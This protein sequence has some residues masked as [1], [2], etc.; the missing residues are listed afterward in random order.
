MLEHLGRPHDIGREVS[1]TASIGIAMVDG[2]VDD[3][4][5]LL[6]RADVAMYAAKT[7]GKGRHELYEPAMRDAGLVPP[8]ARGGAPPGHR[9]RAD[10]RGL[11]ADP[12]PARPRPGRDGSARPLGPPGARPPRPGRLHRG[13]RGERADRAARPVRP[14]GGLPAGQPVAAVARWPPHRPQRQP[15]EPPVPR[16]GPARDDQVGPRPGGPLAIEP[17]A[18]DHRVGDARRGRVRPADATHPRPGRAASRSTTS[19]PASPG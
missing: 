2:E 15:L 6:A 7:S 9:G 8:R 14:P 12:R 19:G 13:R 1:V 17:Q 5:D 18:R 16:P 10:G 11:P 3:A 4:D